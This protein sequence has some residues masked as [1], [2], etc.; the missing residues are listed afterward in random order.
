MTSRAQQFTTAWM[1]LTR[2]PLSRVRSSDKLS[3][4]D[5]AANRQEGPAP[6]SETVWA[7]PV[8]GGAIGAGTAFLVLVLVMVGIKLSLA[9]LWAIAA[10]YCVT[11]ALHEDGLID[12]ADGLAGGRTP[13]RR[14]AIMRDSRVGS[15]GVLAAVLA[16]LGKWSA[17]LAVCQTPSFNMAQTVFTFAASAAMGRMGMVWVV[18]TAMPARR[19]GMASRITMARNRL[20]LPAL[21]SF[22]IGCVVGIISTMLIFSASL[23]VATLAARYAKSKI[24][25]HTG[26]I[27]GATSIIVELVALTLYSAIGGYWF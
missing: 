16:T 26:D 11:G 20:I 22:A 18:A 7:W 19:D 5:S 25:G 6:L 17:Y 13:A 3:A 21:I 14:L 27:L 2:I 10:Q 4:E 8:I 23:V 24:G 15:F 9:M 1:L 12:A